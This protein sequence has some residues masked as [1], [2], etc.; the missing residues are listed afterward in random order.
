M[1]EGI[2]AA[3]VRYEADLGASSFVEE[4]FDD[5][6]CG[7]EG[8]PGSN[9]EDFR[10]VAGVVGPDGREGGRRSAGGFDD[11][12]GGTVEAVDD[13]GDGDAPRDGGFDGVDEMA[14]PYRC[15]HLPGSLIAAERNNFRTILPGFHTINDL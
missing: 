8:F 10:E 5:P 11:P 14:L 9:D 4:F 3:E 13:D 1:K 15:G 6:P 12:D 2:E 7:C